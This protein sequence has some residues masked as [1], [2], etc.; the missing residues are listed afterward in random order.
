MLPALF[1]VSAANREREGA[2]ACFGDFAATLQA[3]A[4]VAFLETTKRRVYVLQ[5]LRLQL[6]QRESD[7]VLNVD[8]GILGVVEHIAIGDATAPH[9]AN[10]V[11]ELMD[12]FRSPL[13][14][15]D[16]ETTEAAYLGP[17]LGRCR[18]HDVAQSLCE[19]VR[20]VFGSGR[21]ERP[22]PIGTWV[23]YRRT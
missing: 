5:R 4:I 16:P 11:V 9:G 8:F 3:I 12:K 18:E 7:L 15:N 6:E 13:F 20:T 19:R 2:Q 1:T 17:G 22:G 10:L 23:S 21:I 14:E